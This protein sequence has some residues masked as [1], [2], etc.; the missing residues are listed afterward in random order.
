MKNT[1]HPLDQTLDMIFDCLGAMLPLTEVAIDDCQSS[2]LLSLR[3][4]VYKLA[5][6]LKT[7]FKCV[8]DL[9]KFI[10]GGKNAE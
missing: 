6:H 3:V 8:D 5:A 4:N 10:H 9:P 7:V 1:N 2:N